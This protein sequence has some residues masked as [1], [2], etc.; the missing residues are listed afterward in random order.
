MATMNQT[1][2]VRDNPQSVSRALMPDIHY[3]F[4]EGYQRPAL[5]LIGQNQRA[6]EVREIVRQGMKLSVSNAGSI[7]GASRAAA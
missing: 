4:A 5:H 1:S 2:S 6:K 7:Q 3:L